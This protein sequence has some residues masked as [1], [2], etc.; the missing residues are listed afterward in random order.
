MLYK[1]L[2]TLYYHLRYSLVMLGKLIKC[3]IYY[4]GVSSLNCF[5]NIGYLLRTL[6][7]KENYDMHIGIRFLNRSC[8]FLKERSFTCLRLRH[9]HTPLTLAYRRYKI[10]NPHSIRAVMSLKM[11]SFIRKNR[12]KVFEIRTTLCFSKAV[13]VNSFKNLKRAKLVCRIVTPGRS[14]NNITRLKIKPSYL[15]RRYIY[16]IRARQIILTSYEAIA[17]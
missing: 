11:N 9:N 5:L 14:L 4:F 7:N 17:V 16:I 13:T 1:P 8:N 15:C 3:R 10:Y 6:V 2:G 12:R